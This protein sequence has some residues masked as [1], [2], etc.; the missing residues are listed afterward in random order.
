MLPVSLW[1]SSCFPSVLIAGRSGNFGACQKNSLLTQLYGI[2]PRQCRVSLAPGVLENDPST[3]VW[4]CNSHWGA[5]VMCAD[6]WRHYCYHC[7]CSFPLLWLSPSS[8]SPPLSSSSSSP[9]SSPSLPFAI[10]NHHFTTIITSTSTTT[11]IITTISDRMQLP[12]SMVWLVDL[13][14]ATFSEQSMSYCARMTWNLENLLKVVSPDVLFMSEV[15]H[16]CLFKGS[17]IQ[18]SSL[19]WPWKT[20]HAERQ[21]VGTP[22]KLQTR[23]RNQSHEEKLYNYMIKDDISTRLS[24]S[25]WRPPYNDC[26]PCV[27]FA[28]RCPSAAFEVLESASYHGLAAE[29]AQK[30]TRPATCWKFENRWSVCSCLVITCY[31]L[32]KK[33]VSEDMVYPH[34]FNNKC[35]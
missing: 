3:A 32:K 13:A 17:I 10:I 16:V 12:S 33:D 2:S 1:L 5:G 34:F 30:A 6:R 29:V 22:Q 26:S 20:M 18:G 15:G 25:T 9:P 31:N 28:Q 4:P 19:C 23:L 21:P 24:R 8:P 11:I 35:C 27:R 7:R 14:V